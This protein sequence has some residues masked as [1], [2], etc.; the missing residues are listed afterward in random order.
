MQSE[1]LVSVITPAYQ[2]AETLPRALA[3]LVAQSYSRW[4]CVV[5]DDGSR[6]STQGVLALV[7]DPRIRHLKLERNEG[8]GFARMVALGETKG[9][10][11]CSLD[12]DD[13]YY[14]GKLSSQVQAFLRDPGLVAVTVGMAVT[15]ATGAL[16][17]VQ[18]RVGTCETISLKGPL[19]LKF[20]FGPTMVRADLARE[21]GYNWRYRRGCDL[22][23]FTRLLCSEGR[24]YCHLPE[25]AYV[26]QGHTHTTID[27]LLYGHQCSRDVYRSYFRRFPADCA[28]LLLS[29]YFKSLVYKAADTFGMA[30]WVSRKRFVPATPQEK[31]DFFAEEERLMAFLEA[32]QF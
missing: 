13:W 5:V 6:D 17:G 21:L 10:F 4:E 27:D 24:P 20:P 12:A 15:D 9:D 1:P 11:V 30:E 23:F 31:S 2:A 16:I 3:S 28:R 22:D 8:R 25:L 19:A 29:S 26:Y 18:G 32:G 7:K 14:S